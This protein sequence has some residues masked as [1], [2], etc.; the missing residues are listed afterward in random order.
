MRGQ[1]IKKKV[2]LF[3]D[4]V[5]FD[6]WNPKLLAP[7]LEIYEKEYLLQLVRDWYGSL[8]DYH[9]NNVHAPIKENVPKIKCPTLIVHGGQ[10]PVAGMEH[11]DFLHNNIRNSKKVLKIIILSIW[12]A[13]L[14]GSCVDNFESKIIRS[15][16]MG[17]K[18][19]K[20]KSGSWNPLPPSKPKSKKKRKNK[21]RI[22]NAFQAKLEKYKDYVL[23]CN[24]TKEDYKKYL[25]SAWW[26]AKRQEKMVEQSRKCERCGKPAKEVHHKHYRTV[27]AEKLE[28]LEALCSECHSEEHKKR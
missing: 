17:N 1:N 14:R 22:M 28:D 11:A 6:K 2:P 25:F 10:D 27:G 8:C 7:L 16:E 23:P 3:A 24:W 15:I 13:S 19:V 9:Y 4:L 12:G 20:K 21:K 18:Y 5:H 26:R